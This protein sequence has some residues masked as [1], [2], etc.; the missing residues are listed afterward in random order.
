MIR[1]DF[2]Q[3]VISLQLFDDQLDPSPNVVKLPDFERVGPKIRDDISRESFL[4]TPEA[5][6]EESNF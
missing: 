4:G 3:R 1:R 5:H 2:G 6:G